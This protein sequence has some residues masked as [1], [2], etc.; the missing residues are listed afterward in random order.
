MHSHK[1]CNIAVCNINWDCIQHW[2]TQASQQ[3]VPLR[4]KLQLERVSRKPSNQA[5]NEHEEFCC[6][7]CSLGDKNSTHGSLR[8]HNKSLNL[9][10]K[11]NFLAT[12]WTETRDTYHCVIDRIRL[13]LGLWIV[14]TLH[15]QKWNQQGKSSPRYCLKKSG[16]ET[17]YSWRQGKLNSSLRCYPQKRQNKTTYQK[18][19]VEDGCLL[20]SF[21]RYFSKTYQL[22]ILI[23]VYLLHCFHCEIIYQSCI[24]RLTSFVYHRMRSDR[25]NSRCSKLWRR[26]RD[27]P[28]PACI[29][30]L[31]IWKESKEIVLLEKELWDE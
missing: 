12:L 28:R 9:W 8:P 26:L 21:A 20:R 17:W 3:N 22:L 2:L 1:H 14:F 5:Y 29:S 13:D 11:A 30:F 25:W 6:C 16:N 10:L 18:I 15:R 27:P 31:S 7:L 24:G 4:F 19:D 23:F